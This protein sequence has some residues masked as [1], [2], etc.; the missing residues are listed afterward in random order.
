MFITI[1]TQPISNTQGGPCPL[2]VIQA[3]DTGSPYDGFMPVLRHW[4]PFKFASIK[5]INIS[6]DGKMDSS[7]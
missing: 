4:H 6:Y 3:A 1:I 2:L 5:V 7:T